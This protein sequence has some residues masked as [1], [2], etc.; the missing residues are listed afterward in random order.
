M[1]I[2]NCFLSALSSKKIFKLKKKMG[3]P[4][5]LADIDNIHIKVKK[6]KRLL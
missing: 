3:F 6:R 4:I 2:F 1:K 5:T